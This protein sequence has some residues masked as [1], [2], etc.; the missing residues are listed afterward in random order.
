MNGRERILTALDLREPDRVPVWIHA[1]NEISIINIARHFTDAVP[2]VKAVNRMDDAEKLQL[3]NA[4]FLIHEELEIDGFTAYE[5]GQ[6][7][8]ITNIDEIHFRDQWGTVLARNPHGLAYMVEPPIKEPQNLHQYEPPRADPAELF[9]LRLARERFKGRLAQFF[10]MRGVF[11]RCYR[12]RGMEDLLVDMIKR[13]D[14]VHHLARTV[15]D[16]NLAL[17][18]LVAEAGADVLIIEDD[19]ADKNGPLMS[20]RHFHEFI[21]PYNQPVL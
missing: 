14:L 11:V 3:L 6:L 21:A 8:N 12:L 20:P 16:Y 17:C 2:G 10:L 7:T 19:M 15:S 9:M 1:I 18:E 4:L 13:P 5:M